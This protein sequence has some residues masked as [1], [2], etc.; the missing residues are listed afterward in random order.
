MAG[1]RVLILAGGRGSRM[2]GGKESVVLG[3]GRT[4]L[5]HVVAGVEGLGLPIVVSAGVGAEIDAGLPILPDKQP[6]E[7]PLMAIHRGLVACAPDDL[8]VVCCDQP[9]VSPA[10][11]RRLLPTSDDARP[12]FF[13]SEDG[14]SL[15]PFPGY[16][17]HG[18]LASMGAALGAGER[19]PRRWASTQ[20]CRFEPASGAEAQLLRSFNCRN[21]LH[22][23][24]LLE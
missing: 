13:E 16:F 1:V 22:A 6:F 2:G 24:G 20:R 15:A 11:V 7:G 9:L 19:S 17:P 12:A 5:Q 23:A 18:A 14:G 10:L 21:E 3:D 4:M 8:L